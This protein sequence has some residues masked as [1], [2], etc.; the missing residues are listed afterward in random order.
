MADMIQIE[1]PSG[2]IEYQV[3]R[4]GEAHDANRRELRGFPTSVLKE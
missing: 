4:L 2:R 3:Y 1:A